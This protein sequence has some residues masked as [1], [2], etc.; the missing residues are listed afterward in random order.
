[1]LPIVQASATAARQRRAAPW[2]TSARTPARAA[3]QSSSLAGVGRCSTTDAACRRR[4]LEGD[5]DLGRVLGVGARVEVEHQP[6]AAAPTRGRAR[7][8]PRARRAPAPR[9]GPP[10][11]AGWRSRSRRCG[12]GSA[13]TSRDA[14][15][16]KRLNAA[17]RARTAARTDLSITRARQ[18]LEARQRHVPELVEVLAHR[19]EALHAHGVRR[20]AAPRRAP[21]PGRP[22]AA[23]AGGARSPGGSPGTAP[24][25]RR[26]RA[27]PRGA[28]AGS[29]GGPGCRGRRARA[30]R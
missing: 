21:R 25:A 30:R 6:R 23:R 3:S 15:S 4:R 8:R 13:A 12:G 19:R 14:R 10:A 2:P 20:R 26:P 11:S 18:L 17:R 5:H 9:S 29:R 28:R 7:A 27:A 16:V 24:P 1:M 22:P